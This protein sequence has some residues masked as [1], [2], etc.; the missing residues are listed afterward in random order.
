MPSSAGTASVSMNAGTG[1]SWTAQSSASWLTITA[2]QSGIGSGSVLFAAAMNPGTS[3]RT[4]TLTVGGQTVS[5]TQA[6]QTSCT[7]TL[8]PTT[9]S[10]N[11]KATTGTI[12]VTTGAGCTW[13]ATTTA[14]WL[15]VQ[16][17]GTGSGSVSYT[18][19][20]NTTGL[21][22]QGVIQIGSSTFTITQRTDAKPNAPERLRIGT[23][24][25][26]Y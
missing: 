19:A 3:A 14:Q 20:A 5:V 1:C 4:G 10:V 6:G 8:D 12:I 23:T 24:T 13:T 18:V 22:R 25:G 11:K 16:G 9:R 7:F 26:G 21:S 15:Q 2:G 17:S